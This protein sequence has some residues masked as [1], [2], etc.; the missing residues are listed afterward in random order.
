MYEIQISLAYY[1]NLQTQIN[2]VTMNKNSISYT[3]KNHLCTGCG[4]CEGACPNSAIKI[5]TK[6]GLFVPS[7]AK[8]LCKNEQGC[9]RCITVCPGVGI[10][11][12]K[13]GK[14]LFE[15]KD[16]IYDSR[17]GY[18]NS[19]FTGYS[20]NKEIRFHSASGGLITQMLIWLL[21]KQYID[22]A[23]V[24][25]FNPHNE[26]LIESFIATTKQE[27]IAAQSS[28]YAPVT[29][30]HAI[31]DIK[32]KNGKFI[33]V[34]LPCHIH[35]FRKYEKIDSTFKNRIFGYFG[36]YCSGSR[37]FNM[38]EYILKERNIDRNGLSYLAYRDEGN[39]G[40]LV[41]NGINPK[42]GTAYHYYQDYQKYAHPLRSFFVPRRCLFCIDHFAELADVSLGD[43]HIAPYW[44]DKIGIN[45][46]IIRDSKWLNLFQEATIDGIIEMQSVVPQTLL[47]SQ[48][49]VKQ[50]KQRVATFMK[51]HRFLLKK[52]LDYDA[53][54]IDSNILHSYL[55]WINNMGQSFIGKK[56]SLW[57]LIDILKRK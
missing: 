56:K 55:S 35:G 5:E 12:C 31:Q 57:F 45:S 22:G 48:V 44:N 18:F 40:G 6:N 26:F 49:A 32:A 23:V 53:N 37:S 38:T 51:I 47:A 52:V 41:V 9:H 19:T 33:I 50:K 30:N 14:N 4:I 16:S 8:E 2:Q 7:V 24:T 25:K 27:L 17:I 34:G 28:K 11:I 15:K 10:D 21:E 1:T 20:Q 46:F 36:L 13:I 39:L 54:L 3:V 43:I 29:L 42:T